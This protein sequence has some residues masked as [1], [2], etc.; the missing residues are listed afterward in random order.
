MSDARSPE[1]V[2]AARAAILA[3]VAERAASDGWTMVAL[4][5]AAAD[6]DINQA[7]VR[8]AFPNGVHDLL[9]A[10]CADGDQRMQAALA[11]M[12]DFE[13]LPVSGR[14]A[15]AVRTRLE[16]D[17]ANIEAVRTATAALAH[18]LN[19]PTA[20]Q[21]LF[22]T[23]DS[24]WR[25]AGDEARDFS[26]YTKRM[27][28]AGVYATTLI[29]WLGDKSEGRAATWRFLDGRLDDVMRLRGVGDAVRRAAAQAPSPAEI[30]SRLRGSPDRGR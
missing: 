1:D 6:A 21:A 27:T 10:F 15:R 7:L 22:H 19:A 24:M 28:L 30:L 17:E 29:T 12:E 9:L 23:V 5:R 2:E 11:D 4:S 20:L 3:G 8:L 25:A 18:P 14:I 26:F 16:I 13:T